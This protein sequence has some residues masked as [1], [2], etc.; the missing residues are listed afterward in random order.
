MIEGVG[1]LVANRYRLERVLGRGGMGRVWLAR[2]EKLHRSVAVK[3]LLFPP[4]ITS[5]ER[6]VLC[7]R[8]MREAQSAARLRHAGIVTVHDVC[9]EDGRPW[10]IME[11]V[12]GRSLA[13]EIEAEGALAP[14]K[15]AK[16]GLQILDALRTAHMAGV[17]HRDV[18]P[19][20]I[21]LE[22]QQAMLTDFG[23]AMIDGAAVITG[24]GLLIGTPAYMAPEQAEG[25]RA[26]SRSDLWSLGATLYAAVEGRPPYEGPNS[27]AVFIAMGKEEPPPARNAGP[28]SAVIH[29]LLR[30]DPDQRIDLDEA[31][32]LLRRA[33]EWEPVSRS[34]PSVTRVDDRARQKE[35]QSALEYGVTRVLPRFAEGSVSGLASFVLALLLLIVLPICAAVVGAFVG[36]YLDYGMRPILG[37]AGFAAGMV[38]G[39]RLLGRLTMNNPFSS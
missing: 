15:V 39:F 38:G 4:Q 18:K 31:E 5:D 26:S 8:S 35:P 30:K 25:R 33:L 29:G 14:E 28:L 24:T 20:N 11:F 17:I 22:D 23:I 16:L 10:I 1:R 21:L 9:E 13:D 27:A 36:H 6:D 19:S 12:P 3:E 34:A 2:D 37:I 7:A 32:R